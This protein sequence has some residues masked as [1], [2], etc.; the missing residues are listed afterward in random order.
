M[1]LFPLL[2]NA[3]N[4]FPRDTS[5]NIQSNYLKAKKKFPEVTPVAPIE[6]N[7]FLSLW[8][9][10]YRTR[11][12]RNLCM[13]IFIPN[14]AENETYACVIFVHGGGW[15][16]GTK[17]NFVPLA[18]QLALK[19]YVTATVEQRLSLEAPYPAAPHDV[20]EA[21]RFLK[22][23]ANIYRIDTTKIAIVG[24]S[25]GAS[26]AGLMAAT[27]NTDTFD[28]PKTAFPNASAEVQ[29]FIN[30]DG[31]IDFRTP[32]EMGRTE[33]EAKTRPGSI[34]LGATFN[35]NPER[36]TAASAIT[37]A[38]A[39]TPPTLY[40]NSTYPRFAYGREALFK[41][42]SQYSIYHKQHTIAGKTVPHGFWLLHPWADETQQQ[43]EEFLQH[44]WH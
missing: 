18:Q 25:S 28:D 5:F 40:I 7:Q 31:V 33:E 36:W 4:E 21:I 43:M 44:I 19:G 13:D 23:N 42:L 29:A 9:Q 20:K 1:C 15:R 2:S 22:H 34:F 16:S 10:T 39:H 37:Y 6:S 12:N 41:I 11:S 26:I 24:A 35:E 32:E 8:N 30:I 17:E 3:Q 38:N 14:R 27:G